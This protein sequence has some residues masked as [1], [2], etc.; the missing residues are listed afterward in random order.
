[1]SM[2][3]LICFSSWVL[4]LFWQFP[5][6]FWPKLRVESGYQHLVFATTLLLGILWSI[7]AGIHDGLK[8]HFLLLTTLVLCHGW[9]IAIWLCLLP[10][11]FLVFIGKL[12]LADAGLFAISHYVVPG[13]FSYLVFL[14]SYRYLQRHL[15]V[16]IFVA[17]FLA[18]AL[19]ICLQLLLSSVLF[20]LDGRYDWQ[21]IN[22]NYLLFSLLIW[23]P[24]ALLNGAAITLMAIYRPDWLRTFYDRE[25]LS[26]ER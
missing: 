1:M 15:F 25:Y 2:L 19:T 20:Y 21:T 11:L 9:R 17:G 6:N 14:L 24:E 16:Y 18:A 7:Q 26:P 10:T 4:L 8:L 13:L 3:Q 23:F 5:R 12:A 22:A